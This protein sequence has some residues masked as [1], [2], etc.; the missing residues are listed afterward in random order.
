MI[1]NITTKAI[2]THNRYLQHQHDLCLM[3]LFHSIL[4]WVIKSISETGMAE[5][6][7][8]LTHSLTKTAVKWALFKRSS[9]CLSLLFGALSS[10]TSITSEL[11]VGLCWVI[12]SYFNKKSRFLLPLQEWKR[13]LL[14]RC[15]N[16]VLLQKKSRCCLW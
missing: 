14:R 12:V 16:R 5:T 9:L 15:R 3:L 8:Y 13:C 2:P 10:N 6:A 7:F 11:S 1:L 4:Q